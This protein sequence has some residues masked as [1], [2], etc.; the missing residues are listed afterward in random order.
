MDQST[1]FCL[2]PSIRLY[3][4]VLVEEHGG[5]PAATDTAAAGPNAV[6]AAGPKGDLL[7]R[8]EDSLAEF[9][10]HVLEQAAKPGQLETWHRAVDAMTTKYS[11]MTTA[12][13]V[14]A[15][16]N[17]GAVPGGGRSGSR[18]GVQRTSAARRGRSARLRDK[19]RVSPDRPPNSKP[20]DERSVKIVI[21]S[22]CP[23]E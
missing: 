22:H 8:M 23:K 15:L 21:F 4:K 18:S 2:S 3:Q 20:A 10:R 19:A 17:F 13:R 14:S 12:G 16:C 5:R 1:T 7:R 9:S 6:A 11:C